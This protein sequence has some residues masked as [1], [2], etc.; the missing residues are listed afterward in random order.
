VKLLICRL[1]GHR[2]V[3]RGEIVYHSRPWLSWCSDE[4]CARCGSETWWPT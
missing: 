3:W 2:W 1:F 4:I